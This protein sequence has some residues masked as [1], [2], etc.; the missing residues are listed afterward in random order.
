MIY[1]IINM[2]AAPGNL[3][4]PSGTLHDSNGRQYAAAVGGSLPV[5]IFPVVIP[6]FRVKELV[7]HDGQ[8]AKVQLEVKY[9]TYNQGS[10]AMV[11][12]T[13]WMQ[14]PRIKDTNGL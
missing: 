12:S 9:V 14:V 3:D 4:Y 10:G 8:V 6:L 2:Y 13:Q 11:S 5:G 7:N 1:D